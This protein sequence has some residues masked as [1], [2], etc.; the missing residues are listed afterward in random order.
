MVGNGIVKV[1]ESEQV[2]CKTFIQSVQAYKE[3]QEIPDVE[4][5][6]LGVGLDGWEWNSEVFESEC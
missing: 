4:K 5:K 3:F 1:F 6:K 2:C